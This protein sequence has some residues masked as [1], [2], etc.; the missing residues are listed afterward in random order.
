MLREGDILTH[1]FHGRGHPIVDGEGNVLPVV[2]AARERGVV[3]DVGHGLRSFSFPVMQRVLEQGVLPTTISSDLHAHD[4]EG[5]V[6]DQATTLSKFLMLGLYLDDVIDRSTAVPAR[7]MGMEEEIG[8]LR[9]G[10]EGDVAVWDLREGEFTFEDSYGNT[11]T[12]HRKLEPV[13]TL[14]AGK[15]FWPVEP[16]E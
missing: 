11:M 4:L 12:G 16:V 6:F 5:P 9:E 2:R 10:A 15:V 3:L 1:T 13:V 14:K 8:T 7:I